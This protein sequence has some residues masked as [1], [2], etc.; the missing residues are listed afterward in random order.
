MIL[1]K[2]KTFKMIN[3]EFAEQFY[4][5]YSLDNWWSADKLKYA[6]I[7]YLN[8]NK[9]QVINTKEELVA[10]TL[11]DIDYQYALYIENHPNAPD[12]LTKSQAKWILDMTD[13]INS[14]HD[15]YYSEYDIQLAIEE[16][17]KKECPNYDF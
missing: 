4:N 9:L 11:D 14:N 8:K 6:I 1:I 5:Y 13:R 2:K 3:E 17:L 7:N 10:I 15:G 16:W 12:E